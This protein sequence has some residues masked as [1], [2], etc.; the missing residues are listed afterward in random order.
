MVSH[1]EA[2]SYATENDFSYH[3]VSAQSGDGIESL[4]FD[5]ARALPNTRSENEKR[6][7][8]VNRLSKK[9]CS[10]F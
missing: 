6:Y 8:E 4:F 7:G 1:E 2:E 9:K 5:I 3:E 10:F